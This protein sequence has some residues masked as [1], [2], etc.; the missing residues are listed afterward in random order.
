MTIQPF[1]RLVAFGAVLGMIPIGSAE[2]RKLFGGRRQKEEVPL[3]AFTGLEKIAAAIGSDSV[4]RIVEMR[5]RNG[6]SQPLTWDLVV[7]D[8][9]SPYLVREYTLGSEVN[10]ERDPQPHYPERVP[11]GFIDKQQLFIDSTACFRILEHEAQRAGVGFNSVN[12]LLRCQEFSEE[13]LWRLTALDGQGYMVGR[14]DLSGA[15]G[16]VLRTIWYVWNRP[17]GQPPL[18]VDSAAPQDYRAVPPVVP[19]PPAVTAV[20][21]GPQE[22]LIPPGAPATAMVPPIPAPGPPVAEVSPA[23]PLVPNPGALPTAPGQMTGQPA[24]PNPGSTPPSYGGSPSVP[25]TGPVIVESLD[26]DPVRV[27]PLPVEPSAEPTAEVE[28]VA[29]GTPR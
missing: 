15:T 3:S 19:Y 9:D 2:E 8:R 21:E 28:P 20:P 14:V 10:V 12:Y 7:Y 13:P 17:A 18:V 11:T 16:T 27:E 1:L 5:G 23:E 6:Q 4:E 24:A 22:G 29:P 25:S 26:S